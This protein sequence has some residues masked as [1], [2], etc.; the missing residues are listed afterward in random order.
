MSTS[1][2]GKGKESPPSAALF[3]QHRGKGGMWERT[4]CKRAPVGTGRRKGES[5]GAG[6]GAA[7]EKKGGQC[8][9]WVSLHWKR[10]GGVL[11]T[12]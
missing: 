12:T 11:Y 5:Y 3:S 2:G 1:E 4:V 9:L 10:K 6:A 8:L 7:K